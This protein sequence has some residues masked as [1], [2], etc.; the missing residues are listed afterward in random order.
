MV[1]VLI[2]GA[3][4]RDTTRLQLAAEVRDIREALDKTG[5]GAAMRIEAELA[6]RPRDLQ[7]HLLRHAPGIIHFS[8][9]GCRSSEGGEAGEAARARSATSRELLPAEEIGAPASE[10]PE[11]GLL[12]EDDR[13]A[14]VA[15]RPEALTELLEIVGR[16][17]SVRCVV[18]NACF[19]APQAERIAQ[20]VG[21]VVGA[22]RS[23]DDRS[24]IAFATGFYRALALG[25]DVQAAFALGRNEIHVRGLPGHDVPELFH[26]PDVD[27][28]GVVLVPQEAGGTEQRER[29][30]RERPIQEPDAGPPPGATGGAP[31]RPGSGPPRQRRRRWKAAILAGAL[32]CAAGLA[33]ALLLPRGRV[34]ALGSSSDAI[35]VAGPWSAGAPRSARRALCGAL[36]RDRQEGEPAAVCLDLPIAFA[37]DAEDARK[38]A[39]DAGAALLI[40][41]DAER[42]A[43]LLLLGALADHELLGRGLPR[44]ELSGAASVELLAAIAR[45]LAHLVQIATNDGGLEPDRLRCPPLAPDT[46]RSLTLLSLFTAM[47][48]SSCQPA[49]ARL[50]ELLGLCQGDGAESEACKLARY[51][52]HRSSPSLPGADA[53]LEALMRLSEPM[54]SASALGLARQ[55]CRGGEIDGAAGLAKALWE[56]P[57]ACPRLAASIAAACALAAQPAATPDERAWLRA[58]EA[59]ADSD[60]VA[61][62]PGP[63]RGSVLGER[64]WWRARAERWDDA[65]GDYARAWEMQPDHLYVLN[66]VEVLLHQGRLKDAEAKLA[67][68][69]REGSLAEGERAQ[70]ALLTWIVERRAGNTARRAV[71]AGRLRQA[72]DRVPLGQRVYEDGRDPVLRP[73]ACPDPDEA[74]PCVFDVLAAP[75][76]SASGEA[77]DEALKA[78]TA[79]AAGSR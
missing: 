43:R 44:V 18:L 26:R 10:D 1:K 34:P 40:L 3:N 71:A 35:V 4:G 23:I 36:D 47:Y 60:E 22:R 55:R 58:A 2:L 46:P 50:R 75:K 53:G 41:I 51:L 56:G 24:A 77:L 45:S 19:T 30:Q 62:C 54:R 63:L 25:K 33:A 21:C 74:A 66:L 20:H 27:P 15:V 57:D 76:T 67:D 17:A 28:R 38:Q 14:A 68:L 7:E 48:T 49:G 72:Y 13:G 32:L 39:L 65:A 78:A 69:Q 5:R 37:P 61:A 59:F 12:F 16:G 42:G 8:G 31:D 70:E 73:L 79:T 11:G 52:H 29:Q 6:V 9:H 64:A